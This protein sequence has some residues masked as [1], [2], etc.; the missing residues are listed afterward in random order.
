MTECSPVI[1]VNS[2]DDIEFGSVGRPIANVEVRIDSPNDEGIGEI[3]VRGES[4]TPGYRN[5][6]EK[7][8]E[9]IRDGWL[10]TGDLGRIKDN[11]LWI[12]GR[13]KNLIVSAAG[14]NIYPEEIE[15]ALLESTL[16]LEAVVFGRKKEGKHGEEVCAVIVADKDQLVAMHG[17][18]KNN[19]DLD[20][21]KESMKVVVDQTNERMAGYKRIKH[22]VVQFEEL[23]KTST[24]KVKRFAY[25]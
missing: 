22:F 10:H 11:H 2:P 7:T 21:V 20:R 3:C 14:K 18:D 5:N 25:K 24:Q 23:K 6:P 16:I 19:P 1:S 8:A 12:T 17:V 15:E 13:A 4:I 9:L